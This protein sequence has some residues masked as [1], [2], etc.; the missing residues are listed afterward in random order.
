MDKSS[1]MEFSER[2]YLPKIGN[3]SK[4]QPTIS[5]INIVLKSIIYE[6]K[7]DLTSLKYPK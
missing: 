5:K 7:P 1:N 6:Q 4:N 2:N 3:T